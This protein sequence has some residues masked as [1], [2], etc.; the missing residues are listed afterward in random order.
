M[1]FINPNSCE[2]TNSELDLFAVQPTQTSIE[3]DSVVEYHPISSLAN[4]A[5]ID[6]D[7]PGSGEQYIDTNNIQLVVRAKIVRPG[8]GNNLLEDST[9]T[10][11]NLLLHSL[12]SQV[13]VSLNG[14]LIS[15]STNTYPY[16]AMLETLLSYGSDAKTSQ[17]TSEMY[18]KD[19][20]GRMDT[21]CVR[22]DAG[23]LPNM[24][25]LAR[26][27]H[28]KLSN[29]F[30]M[31]GHIHADIFQECY[32][33]NEVGIK[34]QLVRSKDAFCLLGD[35]PADTKVE[36]THASLFVRKMK[37]SPSVFLAHAQALQNSTAKYQI[38]RT[39][40]KAL[41]IQQNFQD[42]TFEK[43]ILG[44]LPTRLVVELVSNSAFNGSKRHNP[45]NFQHYNLLEI[46]VYLDSQ[47]QHVLK[48]IQLNY[49]NNLY[50]HAYNS[51]FSGTSKLNRDEATAYRA[52]TTKTV[53]LYMHSI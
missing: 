36:I 32:M 22:E 30:D 38:K 12:F 6:F 33:L 14:R 52:T 15:N 27:A 17:L 43:V 48:P 25:H 13:D 3:E 40:C 1:A 5:L 41:A 39:V 9:V 23:A 16:R 10:P 31:I 7:I 24:G 51:I 50:I 21:F 34:V 29:K 47:Q 8:M 28:A 53:T 20:A 37:I 42:A 49:D 4:R 26:R 2:C 19:D 18:C 46:A 45:F 11:V 44:Q 35:T